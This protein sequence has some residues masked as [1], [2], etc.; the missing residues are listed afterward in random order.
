MTRPSLLIILEKNSNEKLLRSIR[1]ALKKYEKNRDQQ[2]LINAINSVLDSVKM[3]EKKKEQS[4][5]G[6]Q[7]RSKVATNSTKN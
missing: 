2:A 3:D 1:N 5:K 6:F 4:S 7:K